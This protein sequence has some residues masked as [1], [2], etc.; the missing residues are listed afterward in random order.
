MKF[1]EDS[2]VKIPTILHLV[3][4]GYKYIPL[5]KHVR[6][7]E[8]NIFTDIFHE[9]LA[10]INSDIDKGE[11]LRVLSEI[12]IDLENEDLG[13]AFYERLTNRSGVKLIDFENF[14]NNSFHVVTELTYKKDDEEFRPDITVLINGMPLIFIEVKKPNNTNGMLAEYNRLE[15][16]LKNKKFRKF[17]NE[18]QFM[19]FSNNMEYEEGSTQLLQGAFYGTPSYGKPVF[20]FFR[21]E[22]AFS[23]TK[24]LEPLTEE[25]EDFILKDTNLVG[26]KG[27]P[28]FAT[29]KNPF[30]P[31]NRLCKSLLNRDRLKFLLL[32]GLAYVRGTK[33]IEKHIMRYPQFFASKSL[34]QFFEE[35][36]KSGII[37]HTQGSGKTALAFFAVKVLTDYFNAKGVVPKFY[38]IVDRLDLLIQASSEFRSRGLSVHNIS[39]REEFSKDIKSV[40]AV[41]NNLGVPEITVVNIQK[42]QD[43]P[44]V[45]SGKDYNLSIQRVYFLDEVHRSYNPKGSFLSNLKESDSHAIRIGLTGTPLLGDEYNSRVLFG[46]YIHKYYYNSSIADGYTLRLIREEIETQYKLLLKETLEGIEVLKGNAGR[47]LVYAHPKYVEPLLSYIIKDFERARITFNDN[48]IGGMIV[49][50]SSEQAKCMF[51]TFEKKF[52]NKSESS[53]SAVR[54]IALILHDEGTKEERKEQIENFKDGKIDFLLVY[55]MLLTGFDAPRLKK[56][57]LGRVIRTHNLLQALTRVNRTYKD[58]RF[59]Y[60]VDFADI[61]GEFEKTNKAYLEELQAELGDETEKYSKLFLSSKEIEEQVSEIKRVLFNY[62]IENAET[63]TQQVSEIKEKAELLRLSKALNN[64][65][66]LYNIIRFTGNHEHLSLLDFKKISLLAREVNHR[67][68]MVNTKE[69]LD[70]NVDISNLLNEALEDVLFSFKKIKSEEM[71][72]ADELKDALRKAR[73]ALGGN[74]DKSDPRFVSLREE[75]ERLF[76]KK[77][78]TEVS[79]EQMSD[80]LRV[81]EQIYK[82]AKELERKNLLLKA[83][84]DNDEKYTRLHKRLMETDPLTSD[85]VKLFEALKSLKGEIDSQVLKNSSLL[86]NEGF[87]EKMM[88]KLVIDQLKNKHNLPLDIEKSK[89]IN[90]LLVKEYLDEY[91]GSAA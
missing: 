73:E 62:E 46:K 20:H 90:S 70:N 35:G 49:C 18:T 67:L 38:F 71:K 32:Y 16:R 21:E 88:L 68:A 57:Y 89:R 11:M 69:A 74:F 91:H 2:R 87:V 65:K 24:A 30:S 23:T 29:N 56:I 39:S 84:Y 26:I 45:L 42:F 6:D 82:D 44:N 19:L 10:R 5:S 14:D 36:N 4:L 79:S 7:A 83:K 61:E 15:K 54:S 12:S 9:S 75:L 34:V 78:I 86:E 28:E 60:V 55:N 37:W 64:A 66:D 63:F 13:K 58:F 25:I 80:N 48:S 85:E 31:T 50:D 52:K 17:I 40:S 43:D 51:A 76:R 77:N 22:D 59:G 72:L 33:G 27:S 8:T 81:L 41:H 47:E 53:E 1:N 3:R